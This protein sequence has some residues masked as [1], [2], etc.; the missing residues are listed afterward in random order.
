HGQHAQPRYL[1]PDR[2]PL[3]GACVYRCR[4]RCLSASREGTQSR[5]ELACRASLASCR[6]RSPWSQGLASRT[7]QFVLPLGF[8][9]GLMVI[10]DDA[11]AARALVNSRARRAIVIFGPRHGIGAAPEHEPGTLQ[12]VDDSGW[13]DRRADYWIVEIPARELKQIAQLV[14]VP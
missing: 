1:R 3:A 9:V 11:R 4:I 13:A 2:R 5:P 10:L 7:A 12:T 6:R 8:S 14:D